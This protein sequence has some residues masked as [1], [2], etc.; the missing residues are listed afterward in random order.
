MSLIKLS[1]NAHIK[2]LKYEYSLKKDKITNRLKEF[3]K[4]YNEPYSWFYENAKMELKN[5][6]KNDECG[7]LYHSS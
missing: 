6:N 5:V 7:S 1:D 2:N 3:D 4:F